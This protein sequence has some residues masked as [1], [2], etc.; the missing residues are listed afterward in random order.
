MFSLESSGSEELKLQVEAMRS[1]VGHWLDQDGAEYARR[2]KKKYNISLDPEEAKL[3]AAL[4]IS[5]NASARSKKAA[6]KNS[7][8]DHPTAN[9]SR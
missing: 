9:Q 5:K 3:I 2:F 4:A 7:N 8:T 6:K 1:L